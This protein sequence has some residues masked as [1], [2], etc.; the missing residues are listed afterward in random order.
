[1]SEVVRMRA[2]QVRSKVVA[3]EA[4]L[5][6]AYGAEDKFLANHLEGAIPLADFKQQL[7]GLDKE[8]EI[9]F[10]CG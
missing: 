5:V 3:G 7:S 1:M 10:Y 9:V 6:C 8:T 2:E 4:L